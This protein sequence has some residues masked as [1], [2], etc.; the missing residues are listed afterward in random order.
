MFRRLKPEQLVIKPGQSL[1]L[2]GL[3]RITPTTPCLTFLACVFVPFGKHI[4]STEKAIG[5]QTQQRESGVP[6]IAKPSAGEKIASA[7]KFRLKWDVTK[8]RAGPITSPAAIGLKVEKLPYRVFST[9]IL[10][11]GCGWIEIVAQIRKK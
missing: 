2:G 3:I 1:L 4:T 7:G 9:D 6:S 8:P 10:I 5:I 11:E